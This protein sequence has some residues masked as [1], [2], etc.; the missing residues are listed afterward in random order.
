MTTNTQPIDCINVYAHT[1]AR[2]Q[3]TLTYQ[4]IEVR[5]A[6]G[7]AGIRNE[8]TEGDGASP[9]GSWPLRKVLYRPDR[10]GDLNSRLPIEAIDPADGWCD[11]PGSPHY[12]RPVRLPYAA[13]HECMWRDDSLYDIVVVLGHN[14]DPVVPG[15][16]S[17]IFF[18]LASA[19]YSPTAGCI[20]VAREHMLA[21]LRR[22]GMTAVMTVHL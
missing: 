8:K 7:R 1:T 3:G 2:C 17:A 4:D 19:D 6:L 15:A 21:V 9:A 10:I 18:H 16:G 13:S 14:D 11:E 12:N 5:C 20:A 22:C